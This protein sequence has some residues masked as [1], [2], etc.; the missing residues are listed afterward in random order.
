MAGKANLDHKKRYK[1]LGTSSSR[2]MDELASY[3]ACIFDTQIAVI[4]FVD[5]HDI[6]PKKVQLID[7]L[8]GLEKETNVCSFAIINESVDS[9]EESGTAP[10]LLTNALMAA[11]FG[12][13]FYAVAPIKTEEG[14]QM[15]SVCIL[16]QQ[17]R[18]FLP[19][20]QERLAWVAGMI[21]KR[22]SKRE[23]KKL[24]V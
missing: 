7:R 12:M 3:T 8:S 23:A 10:A 20:D 9:F 11:E 22:M 18:E 16:D 15:G 13:R 1:V 2:I 17:R 19:H 4:N 5:Q 14:V 6:W 24:F 21:E